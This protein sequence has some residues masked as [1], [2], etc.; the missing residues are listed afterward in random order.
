MLWSVLA[1][2]EEEFPDSYQGEKKEEFI[3]HG[4]VE[5]KSLPS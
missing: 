2:L 5:S 1:G 4:D 3:G